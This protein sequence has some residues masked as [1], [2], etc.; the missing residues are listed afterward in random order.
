MKKIIFIILGTICALLLIVAGWYYM[1][2][3]KYAPTTYV[4]ATENGAVT[5]N[6]ATG[7]TSTTTPTFTV[8]TVSQHNDAKSCYSVISK[9]V[10]DLTLW[11]NLHP[12]GAKGI[13]SICGIDGTEKFM[14]KHK[15]AE[16]Q[17]TI[18]SRYKIG[19]LAQ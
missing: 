3:K 12:G 14:K 19:N 17:M 13:L 6:T 5:I 8:A 10:Y 15:G 16:K 18:L 2:F 1:N 9:S 7:L 11:V 4:S